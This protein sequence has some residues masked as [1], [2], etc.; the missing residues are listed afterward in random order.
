MI[1]ELGYDNLI[2]ISHTDID[3]YGSQYLT[4]LIGLNAIYYNVDYGQIARVLNL[5]FNKLDKLNGSTLILISDLNITEDIANKMNNF[6][7]GNKHLNFEYLVI[8]HHITGLEVSKKNS[9]YKLDSSKCASYLV[10]NWILDSFFKGER[11]NQKELINKIK[12]TM[13]F[14]DAHDRWL[15]DH[16]MHNRANFVSS[17]IFSE[18]K[19]PNNMEDE[20]RDFIFDFID[21]SIEFFQLGNSTITFEQKKPLILKDILKKNIDKDVYENDDIP[22]K[23]KMINYFTKIYSNLKTKTLDFEGKS[24]KLIFNM[25]SGIFQYLSHYYLEDNKDIDFM[26]NVKLGGNC[27]FR[28]CGDINVESIARR[29]FNG[30][31]HKNAAG[32]NLS[33]YS[34][35][36]EEELIEIF[37]NIFPITILEDNVEI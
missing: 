27:S 33:N 11:R 19:F 9:W 24:F 31:G 7:R 3:G 26:I 21:K 32:G 30:G 35:N 25:D 37:L 2:H 29:Y 18:L 16:P 36:S 34:F 6:K 13:E 20:R 15:V 28:S 22:V 1:K 14:I 17:L 12:F 23:D 5:A 8:D 10:G 4:K